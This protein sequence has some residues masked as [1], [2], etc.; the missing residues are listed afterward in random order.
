MT[1]PV[2]SIGFVLRACNHCLG[3]PRRRDKSKKQAQ[4]ASCNESPREP[5]LTSPVGNDLNAL[6][7]PSHPHESQHEACTDE[8]E[9]SNKDAHAVFRASASFPS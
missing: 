3:N 8:L 1:S 2:L 6:P 7:H 5:G 9:A 4:A